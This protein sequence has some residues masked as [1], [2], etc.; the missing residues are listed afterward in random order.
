MVRSV[1]GILGRGRVVTVGVEGLGRVVTVGVV[2]QWWAPSGFLAFSAAKLAQRL[3]LREGM[4][5]G[6]DPTE[7]F[8]QL[9]CAGDDYTNGSHSPPWGSNHGSS[10][11]PCGL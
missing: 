7:R 4:V 1:G 8:I 9:T 5:D 11:I 2:R 6:R 10:P 3:D